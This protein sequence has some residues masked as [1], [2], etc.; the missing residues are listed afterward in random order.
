MDRSV[1]RVTF[2][3]ALLLALGIGARAQTQIAT[4]VIQGTVLDESGAV[5]PAANVEVKNPDTNFTRSL[6]TDS[7]GRFVFLQLQ[8]GRYLLTV[9]KQGFATLVQENLDLTVGQTISLSLNMKV[10]RL[11]E[12]ITITAA[13]TIDTVKTESST[14]L[15]ERALKPPAL[16]DERL[17]S[18][19]ARLTRPPQRDQ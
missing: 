2:C 4:G 9:S 1:W 13:P 15:N 12:K 11:E 19:H 10:S 17:A 8:P 18:H 6:P 3:L 14:T 7:S 16:S 5:L